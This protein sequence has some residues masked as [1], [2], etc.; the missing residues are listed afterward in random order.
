MKLV[1]ETTI[2]WKRKKFTDWGLVE[3]WKLTIDELTDWLLNTVKLR[4]ETCEWRTENWPVDRLKAEKPMK[5]WKL[6]TWKTE[7][8]KL[9]W[10]KTE[11]FGPLKLEKPKS[12]ELID[13]WTG[14]LMKN[15]L[16]IEENWWKLIDCGTESW[17]LKNPDT[18]KRWIDE[19]VGR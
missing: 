9:K 19:P 7:T 15:W 1:T 17:K 12:D 2:N 8:G 14:E 6:K 3:K 5:W 10:E 16:R 4:P 18:V 13:W 11:N